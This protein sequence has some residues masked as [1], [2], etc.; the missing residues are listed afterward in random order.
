MKIIDINKKI[1]LPIL[2]PSVNI[3]YDR[4]DEMI[5]SIVS[6]IH[7]EIDKWAEQN[8]DEEVS[9]P[10]KAAIRNFENSLWGKQLGNRCMLIN[11]FLSF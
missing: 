5:D 4:Y 1:D 6:L 2:I 9:V 10:I 7:E 8:R 3:D 11:I